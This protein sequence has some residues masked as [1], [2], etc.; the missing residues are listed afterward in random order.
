[1]KTKKNTQLFVAQTL[2][3]AIILLQSAVPFLGYVPLGAV[4]V[5]ASAV[6]LP[7]TAALAAITLGPKSGFVVAFFWAFYSWIRAILHPGTFGA[8]LFSNPFVAFI[9]RILVGLVIGYLAQRFFKNQLKPVWF[10][11]TLGGL[12]AFINTAIV[13]VLT[14][15]SLTFLPYHGYGIP[16]ENLFFWLVAI[17][18]FNFF[19]EFVMNG[20]LVAAIGPVLQRRFQKLMK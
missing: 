2:F 7:A 12:S 20:V 11:F 9:P 10:L 4:V 19:F 18:A 13:I 3:V 15:L 6:I 17:L 14:W 1:M 16:K 8:L 5:G